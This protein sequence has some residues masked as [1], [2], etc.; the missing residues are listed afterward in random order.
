MRVILNP[1]SQYVMDIKQ[2]LRERNGYCPCQ[3]ERTPDTKCRCKAFREQLK[4]GE[5]GECHCGLYIAV[6]E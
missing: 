1:D 6:E 4:R 3:I 2:R 5:P